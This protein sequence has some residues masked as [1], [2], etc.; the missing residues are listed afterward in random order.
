[1]ALREAEIT[2]LG[3][4]Y[5]G[6]RVIA[7]QAGL[8]SLLSPVLAVEVTVTGIRGGNSR[9]PCRYELIIETTDLVG[10]IPPVWVRS[11]ADRA[12]KHVNIW[13]ADKSF[14]QWTGSQLP[15]FC[16]YGF[17]KGWSAAPA[18]SRTLGAALEYTKQFLNTENHDSSAR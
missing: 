18:G 11:P 7:R 4:D 5:P 1:M 10:A 9:L 8:I 12:I 3:A 6:L 16:W 13:P 14:C 2:R 17:A 15:S